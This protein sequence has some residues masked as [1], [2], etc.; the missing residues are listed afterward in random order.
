MHYIHASNDFEYT[1]TYTSAFNVVISISRC[2][3][4][5]WTA[6]GSLPSLSVVITFAEQESNYNILHTAHALVERTPEEVLK[7][8]ILVADNSSRGEEY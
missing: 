5:T 7:E 2:D 1:T 3:A 6:L 8:I 4:R